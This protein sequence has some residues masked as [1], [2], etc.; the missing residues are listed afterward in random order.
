[1]EEFWKTLICFWEIVIGFRNKNFIFSNLSFIFLKSS[2]LPT[3]R[4][5][6]EGFLPPKKGRLKKLKKIKDI[7]ATLIY[8]ESPK[9]LNRT[10]KQLHDI[11]GDRPAV[12]SRELTKLYEEIK[13]GLLS[14]LYAYFLKKPIK[15]E[16][17]ILIG[18]NDENV[19][20]S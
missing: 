14:E 19:Y 20:F 10:L 5:L 16:C 17:V 6:F 8:Y 9:R 1:M 3:D 13:R 12:V 18:K 4:F 7:D 15:G 2:G 11:L